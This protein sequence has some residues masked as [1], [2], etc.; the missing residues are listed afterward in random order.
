MGNPGNQSMNG[1][2][3]VVSA[4]Y[5]AEILKH[6]HPLQRE[7][8]DAVPFPPPETAVPV[9]VCRISGEAA[10]DDCPSTS[11]EYFRPSEAPRVYCTVH[12]RYAVDARDG[13]MATEKT[14]RAFVRLRPFTVL[15]PVFALW[16]AQHGY[17]PP[18]RMEGSPAPTEIVVTYPENG[19][20]YFVDPDTPDK[21]QS[22]PLQ[23]VV[24]PQ[25]KEI[26]WQVDGRFFA[27]TGYPYAARLPLTRGIHRIQ[28]MVPSAGV[29]SI[30]ISI[31]VE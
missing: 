17:N 25:V 16:G 22:V 8:I 23:A 29:K 12:R 14:P 6:L 19:A 27:R 10:G 11:L 9:T 4:V 31:S 28:A 18:P 7:G 5:V 20:R 13:S 26:I 15:P 1:V 2:A 21:F 24:K 30:E 3:G